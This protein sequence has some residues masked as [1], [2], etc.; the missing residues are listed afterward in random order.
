MLSRVPLLPPVFSVALALAATPAQTLDEFERRM[1]PPLLPAI[2]HAVAEI[3]REGPR[4]THYKIRFLL[5]LLYA[6]IAGPG[7]TP[8]L[9][10]RAALAPGW[11]SISSL[12][13]AIAVSLNLTG[14]LD[15]RLPPSGRFG[16][17]E[18]ESPRVILSQIVS[19]SLQR[20]AAK[21]PQPLV[22]ADKIEAPPPSSDPFVTLRRR[23][24]PQIGYVASTP[25]PYT[26][27]PTARIS[28]SALLRSTTPGRSR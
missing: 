17:C 21:S 1:P 12:D 6:S 20:N 26:S 5:A 18:F 23:S 14:Y 11:E 24:S 19:H 27:S 9:Q 28:S 3:D 7:A 15:S 13:N 25:A 2:E 4:A 8:F 10:H 16:L 22:L